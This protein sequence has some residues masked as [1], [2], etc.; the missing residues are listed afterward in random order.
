[1]EGEG[2]IVVGGSG[3]V[4]GAIKA[5][6]FNGLGDGS[7]GGLDATSFDFSA[8]AKVTTPDSLSENL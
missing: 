1:L 2:S 5:S 6:Q 8:A 4:E 3:L 7:K